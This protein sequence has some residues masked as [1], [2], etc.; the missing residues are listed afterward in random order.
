MA[1]CRRSRRF[2]AMEIGGDPVAL[3]DRV[4]PDVVVL[5]TGSFLPAIYDQLETIAWAGL[6]IVSSAE[7][8]AFPTLQSAELA[9][10][11]PRSSG[12]PILRRSSSAVPVPDRQTSPFEDRQGGAEP[13]APGEF[14]DT[15]GVR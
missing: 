8:L 12:C 9:Q 5:T 2:G 7:E 6:D 15:P 10:E 13:A 11:R 14:G 1:G 4:K 3:F